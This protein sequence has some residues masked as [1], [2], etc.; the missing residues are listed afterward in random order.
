MNE[1]VLGTSLAPFDF[2]KQEIAVNSW[3]KNGFRVV[4][5][6]TKK[7]IE[8]LEKHFNRLKVEFVEIERD[9]SSVVGRPLPYIQD[10]LDVVAQRTK[11]ICGFIN[12]DI[13]IADMPEGMFDFIEKETDKSLIFVHRNEI[14]YIDDIYNMNWKIH[15]EGIDLFFIDKSLVYNFY[16]DG[17]FVQSVWD[18]GILIKS[19]ILGIKT[20]EL[21]NPIAFHL[22]HT[23]KWDFKTSFYLIEEFNNKYFED[24]KNIYKRA[25]D[26]YYNILLEKCEQICFYQQKNYR[27]L[28][29]GELND[30]K[31]IRSIEDQDYENINITDDWEE[32]RNYDYVFYIKKGVIYNKIFCR[33]VMYIM[34]QFNCKKLAMGRFF[35]SLIEKKCLYN[36]LNRNISLLEQ[37]NEENKLNT[38][39]LRNIQNG[40]EGKLFLPVSYEKIDINNRDIIDHRGLAGQVYLMPAGIRANEWY[41]INHNKF[42]SLKI[43]GYIDNNKEKLGM[44]SGM[45]VYSIDRLMKKDGICVIIASKYYSKEIFQQLS[46]ILNEDQILNASLM[47]YINDEGV[48]YYFDPQKY[49]NDRGGGK[50]L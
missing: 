40:K 35:V 37:I 4:S 34:E 46:K 2:K 12:S 45:P 20:K 27:C 8:V 41:N 42:N 1:I 22:R 23:L 19:D 6:N 14:D 24:H 10:I 30:R 9:A 47:L 29:V 36:E 48:I 32:E 31:T 21:V 50:T 43:E 18:L 13:I 25:W 5:C 39:I 11:H 33:T 26:S 28:F 17:F 38:L 16:D 7:E 15:F 49:K 44:R 3:I